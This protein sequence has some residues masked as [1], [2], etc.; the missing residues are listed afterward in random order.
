[1]CG[2]ERTLSSSLHDTGAVNLA[3]VQ[4]ECHTGKWTVNARI[5]SI[6]WN[7]SKFL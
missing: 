2:H 5:K 4:C 3:L 7:Y 1:M 6:D